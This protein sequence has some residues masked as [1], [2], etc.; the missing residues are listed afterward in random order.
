MKIVKSKIKFFWLKKVGVPLNTLPSCRS[1]LFW[2]KVLLHYTA[3]CN[4]R[5][6][7][8][9]LSLSSVLLLATIHLFSFSTPL[10]HEHRITQG[11]PEITYQKENCILPSYYDQ[12]SWFFS[13]DR[14]H[15]QASYSYMNSFWTD[16]KHSTIWFNTKF[17]SFELY[18]QVIDILDAYFSVNKQF[19]SENHVSIGQILDNI[20]VMYES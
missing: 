17:F 11:V 2:P 6:K 10:H 5:R 19:L 20:D 3:R 1:R 14:E 9:F 13:D 18:S 16:L 15:A 8:L 4:E 12:T 7:L